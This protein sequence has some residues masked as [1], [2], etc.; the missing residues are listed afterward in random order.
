MQKLLEVQYM[1]NTTL[2]SL[3]RKRI[4]LVHR[5]FW[6]QGPPQVHPGQKW[7]YNVHVQW[8]MKYRAE[9]QSSLWDK[10]NNGGCTPGC[11]GNCAHLAKKSYETITTHFTD[12][13]HSYML[14]TR[15]MAR[16]QCT[17]C[18]EKCTHLH[19]CWSVAVPEEEH[20]FLR[21]NWNVLRFT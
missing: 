20:A 2:I 3:L 9:K 16:D 19:A 14:K 7:L 21:M 8:C 10:R 13:R 18:S 11:R 1:D 12:D 4:M 6:L 5:W 17:N 15:G